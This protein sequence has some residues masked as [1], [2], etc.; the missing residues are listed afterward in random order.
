[1]ALLFLSGKISDCS[2]GVN[3]R[4]EH[5]PNDEEDLW[6]DWLTTLTGG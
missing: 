2:G 5:G 4:K 3:M 1:M 6:D